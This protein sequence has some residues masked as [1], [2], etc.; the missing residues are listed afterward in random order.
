MRI[1][2]SFLMVLALSCAAPA[3][4]PSM[5]THHLFIG[6]Y[7]RNTSK[8]IHAVQLDATTGQLT[9]PVLAA[10][11]A[12]P[13]YLA[14]SPHREVLYAVSESDAMASAFAI[15]EDR[16][17]LKPLAA[18]REAGGKAPAHLAVDRTGR[19]LLVA[20]Y[21]TGIVASLPVALDGTL[22]PP[23]SVIPHTGSSVH[24]ERQTGPHA[25]SVTVS[26]DN[27]FVFA[28]DLGLDKI[29]RYQLEPGTGKLV[30][31]EPPFTATPPGS[32]PRHFAFAPN[33]RHAFAITEMG[34]TLIAYRYDAVRGTLTEVDTKSTLA[35]DFRGENT[36]AAVRVHPNGR[37]VYAS[38]RGPDTLAVFAFDEVSGRLALIEFVPSGGKGPR[39]FAL[40]PDGQWLVA[41]HQY[42]D[43]LTVFRVSRESGR[44]SPTPH[45]ATVSTPVSV[46]FLD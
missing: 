44:L 25:H 36:S 17:H 42:S 28:C 2:R 39:D 40:S 18:A 38:N 32:G 21:H 4:F 46:L 20:N 37:F 6:T 15:A 43:L 26:P 9:T 1:R 35:P 11:T 23:V 30:P 10:E 3:A 34:G 7:T 24:P 5:P 27:R 31:G 41:A 33:G 22:Q 45:T 19:V 12:N 13:S 8:G 29:F 16:L 14:L